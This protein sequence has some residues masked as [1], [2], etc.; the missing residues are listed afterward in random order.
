[1]SKIGVTRDLRRVSKEA[2]Q[3]A[4]D[5]VRQKRAAGTA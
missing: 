4:K 3:R 1:M 2:I 5:S